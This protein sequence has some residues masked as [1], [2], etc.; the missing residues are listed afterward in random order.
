MRTNLA[1]RLISEE[2]RPS[3]AL[4]PKPAKA[5]LQSPTHRTFTLGETIWEV[6]VKGHGSVKAA[7]FSM[8]DTDPSLLRRQILDGTLPLKKLFEADPKALAAFGEFLVEHYGHA[9]KSK[10][11]IAR[12]RL[13]ELFA[14]LLEAIE[15]P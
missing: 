12:E 14:A 5:T 9:K 10:K 3:D 6:L 1:T 4:R 2:V 11:Q 13:P 8:G 7:A 15:E